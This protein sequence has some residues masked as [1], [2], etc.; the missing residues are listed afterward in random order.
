MKNLLLLHLVVLIFGFT[1]IL[2]KLITIPSDQLVWYRMFFA[3]CS[4]AVYL[5]LMKKSFKMKRIGILKTIGVGFIIAA[6]WV[7][8]FEAIKQ[9]NVSIAL[10][11]TA[12]G[13]LFTALLEPIFFKRKL[14]FYELLLGSIVLLGLYFIFQFETDNSLGIWLGVL[15]A[16]LASL[17]TVMNGQLI[18]QYDSTRISFYELGGG[19]IAVTLY[20]LIFSRSSLPNFQLS[21]SDWLWMLVLAIVCTAF[22]FVAS[23]KVMEELTPFTVSLSINL[24]PIYGI[25]LALLIFGESEKMSPGFYIGT[26]LILCSLFLNVWIKR[27]LKKKGYLINFAP[28]KDSVK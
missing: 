1:A 11:A 9:S 10:A 23:V 5:V 28:L 2:G 26:S 21:S 20:F 13:S 25:L 16:F 15:A 17:F 27:R 22:A 18:K 8:F 14:H 4:L 3:T 12:T 6:H 19:V 24:E 7:F